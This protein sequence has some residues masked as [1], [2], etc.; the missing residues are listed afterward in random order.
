MS[1]TIQWDNEDKTVLYQ[2]IEGH[3]SWN[4]VYP[5]LEQINS[6]M[7][8]IDHKVTLIINMQNSSMIPK[9]TLL[10]IVKLRVETHPNVNRVIMVG[11]R[12]FVQLLYNTLSRLYGQRGYSFTMVATLE[13]A[14]TMADSTPISD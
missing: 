11:A 4:D 3:W 1:I 6:M 9:G 13:E 12:N 5:I 10:N 2:V 7:E 14:R 8:E